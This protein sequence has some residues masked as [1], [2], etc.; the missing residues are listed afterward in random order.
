MFLGI[1]MILKLGEQRR[2]LIIRLQRNSSQISLDRSRLDDSPSIIDR[3][4]REQC[5][6]TIYER[7]TPINRTSV[8]V[9]LIKR[10]E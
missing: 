3:N 10:A 1:A 6:E 7:D 9:R 4:V 5:V 2:V 8:P